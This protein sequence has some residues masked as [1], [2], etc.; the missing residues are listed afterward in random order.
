MER[1]IF[2]KL[3][4]YQAIEGMVEDYFISINGYYIS[5]LSHAH[6]AMK[7]Y[8]NI[9]EV[10]KYFRVREQIRAVNPDPGICYI[11]E[12]PDS[13]LN[14]SVDEKFDNKLGY[15]KPRVYLYSTYGTHSLVT[16]T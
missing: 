7:V 13:L 9:D 6:L 8:E 10:F 14:H 12:L 1:T 2:D 5:H 16:L 3:A 11:Y 4:L 15:Y